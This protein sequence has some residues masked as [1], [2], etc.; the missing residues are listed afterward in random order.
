MATLYELTAEY[1][2]LLEMAEEQ[3]LT[4]VNTRPVSY[5]RRRFNVDGTGQ[6]RLYIT[7]HGIY[8]AYLNG[9]RVGDAV[10]APGTSEYTKRLEYQTLDVTEY[11]QT[12]G[13]AVRAE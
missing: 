6:G 8:V 11:L 3:N 4:Q 12:A 13:I 7:A 10:L 2:E 1:K 9:R 5:A